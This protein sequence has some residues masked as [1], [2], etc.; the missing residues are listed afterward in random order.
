MVRTT[1]SYDISKSEA[2]SE[3]KRELPSNFKICNNQRK[4]S[5][6]VFELNIEHEE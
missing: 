1:E 4:N 2:M 3:M 5:E 6:Y